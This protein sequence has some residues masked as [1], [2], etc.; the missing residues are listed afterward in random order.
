MVCGVVCSSGTF[1]L[2]V[3]QHPRALTVPEYFHDVVPAVIGIALVHAP[4]SK[5]F[6]KNCVCF[7]VDLVLFWPLHANSKVLKQLW[8]ILSRPHNQGSARLS[9][10]GWRS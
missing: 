5:Q 2:Y 7:A 8:Q 3:E 6:S 4:F 9:P 1:K 10:R